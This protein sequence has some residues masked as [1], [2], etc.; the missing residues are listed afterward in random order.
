MHAAHVLAQ[1][2]VACGGKVASD[3]EGTIIGSG[4]GGTSVVITESSAGGVAAA[5]GGSTG[6]V[7]TSTIGGCANAPVTFQLMPSNNSATVWCIGQSETCGD[8]STVSD[9]SGTLQQDTNCTLDCDTCS[10]RLCHPTFC[11]GPVVLTAQGLT[12]V[13]DGVYATASTCGAPAAT[14]TRTNCA[15]PGKYTYTVYAFPNPDPTNAYGCTEATTLHPS[16]SFSLDFKYPP[17]AP[18][19]VTLPPGLPT[20]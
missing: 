17:S 4:T 14:C 6:A 16:V 13:W 5:S 10:L 18:V 12:S 3:S 7:G 2:L 8:W 11:R 19:V 20:G 1:L 15:L 9:A